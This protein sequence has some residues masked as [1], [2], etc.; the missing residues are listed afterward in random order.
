[1]HSKANGVCMSPRAKGL[2]CSSTHVL[3]MATAVAS[4]TLTLATTHASIP[5]STATLTYSA[6]V[7]GKVINKVSLCNKSSVLLP[8]CVAGTWCGECSGEG[9]GV[10]ALLNSCSN[11]SALI[12][13]ALGKNPTLDSL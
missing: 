7:E 12:I 9:E 8:H 13:V 11:T 10:S 3:L 4:T 5:T 2:T 6:L 1:M